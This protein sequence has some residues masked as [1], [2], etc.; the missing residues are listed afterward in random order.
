MATLL[1][2]LLTACIERT[3]HTEDT[4]YTPEERK[5]PEPCPERPC[6]RTLATS[7]ADEP[8]ASDWG[9]SHMSV[10]EDVAFVRA[11]GMGGYSTQTSHISVFRVPS[12]E[13][14]GSWDTG[15]SKS[16]SPPAVADVDG[17]GVPEVLIGVG[18]EA[19]LDGRIYMVSGA[20]DGDVM[21]P[22]HNVF[23]FTG[24]DHAG[25]SR[26]TFCD[27]DLD[28]D[29][30][31]IA[32]GFGQSANDFPGHLFVLDSAWRGDYTHPAATVDLPL[33][34]EVAG[35]YG[36]MGCFDLNSDGV[37]ELLGWGNELNS[38][39]MPI[40]A[41]PPSSIDQAIV[42]SHDGY[43][44]AEELSILGDVTGDGK[45]DLGLYAL[46]TP[47][48]D[49]EG[50]LYILPGGTSTGGDREALPIQVHGTL[51]GDAMG[52]SA[53]SGDIDGDGVVDLVVGA[54]GVLPGNERTGRVLVFKGPVSGILTD[55]DAIAIVHGEYRS[56]MFGRQVE[57]I[58]ADGDAFG[59]LLVTAQQY[60]A[61]Y[62]DGRIYVIPGA[63]LLAAGR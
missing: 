49:R 25:V 1:L 15:V 55:A 58:D 59:D 17:D 40:T 38:L 22:D 34:Q 23:T 9:A 26:V 31:P 60:P 63:A 48:G 39:S 35:S 62:G 44:V 56:D 10:W 20:P 21:L 14:L 28:G 24:G 13:W 32:T 51:L 3:G 46:E 6:V 33:S 18:D 37:D 16:V 4:G 54:S 2:L 57:V 30:D 61:G 8:G 19:G 29:L 45:A 42:W 5:L 7:V 41:G 52:W 50:R 47:D 43:D 27:A 12:L 36:A 53:A 11:G